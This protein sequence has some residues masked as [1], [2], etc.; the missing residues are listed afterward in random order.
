MN[1]KVV[2]S[3]SLSPSMLQLPEATQKSTSGPVWLQQQSTV[4]FHG[5]AAQDRSSCLLT[6]CCLHSPCFVTPEEVVVSVKLGSDASSVPSVRIC[7]AVVEPIMQAV[8]MLQKCDCTEKYG[9][10]WSLWCANQEWMM[11]GCM[12]CIRSSDSPWVFSAA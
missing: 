3:S 2:L 10:C 8:E 1:S 5:T 6:T 11:Y 9:D 12:W 4:A 7:D